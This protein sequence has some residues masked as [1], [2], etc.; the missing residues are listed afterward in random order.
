MSSPLGAGRC[1]AGLRPSNPPGPCPPPPA[2]LASGRPAFSDHPVYMPQAAVGS[3]REL[4]L[5]QQV[6]IVFQSGGQE[7]DIK[8]GQGWSVSPGGSEGVFQA[9]RPAAREC[10]WAS[11]FWGRWAHAQPP[12]PAAASPP[13]SLVLSVPLCMAL[14]TGLRI[15]QIQ[16][17]FPRCKVMLR[18]LAARLRSTRTESPAGADAGF[19]KRQREPETN[20]QYIFGS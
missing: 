20:C 6:F 12:P 8:L 16:A 17:H 10:P 11:A 18:I 15:H 1:G 4:G 13:C 2:L 5:K 14:L 7:S 9:S 3:D 19:R